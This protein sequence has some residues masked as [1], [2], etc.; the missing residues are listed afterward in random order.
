MIAVF[1]GLNL[2][3]GYQ[4]WL[5]QKAVAVYSQPLS[6][7]LA[8]VQSELAT[9][10]VTL[11]APVPENQPVM[12]QLHVNYSPV[13]LR[14]LSSAL[15]PRSVRVQWP[16]LSAHV[17]NSPF[18][19]IRITSPGQFMEN[20]NPHFAARQAKFPMKKLSQ[21]LQKYLIKH[22]YNF[23]SYQQLATYQKGSQTTVI[24]V[25]Q[26]NGYP[27]FSARLTAYLSHGQ[28]QSIRQTSFNVLGAANPR[29]VSSPISALLSLSQYMD[30]ADLNADNTIQ[31]IRL[32][33]YSSVISDHGWYLAPVWRIDTTLGVFY[34]NAV[35]GEVGVGVA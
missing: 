31:D 4:W 17:I 26:Y 28:L 9:H 20:L 16:G 33:Y 5:L 24:Y 14:G 19:S 8:N 11:K 25:Q 21:G 34:V 22:G 7:Q 29:Q 2:F 35:T 13:S 30:K 27:I 6:D 3:L 32:G 10:G 1:L 12:P 23:A 15:W 18:G